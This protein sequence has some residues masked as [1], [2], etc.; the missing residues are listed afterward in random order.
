M[1]GSGAEQQK[2]SLSLDTDQRAG[3]QVLQVRELTKAFGPKALW[4]GSEIR[5][6]ARRADRDHRA[7]RVG[8]DDAAE[9]ADRARP[10]PTRATFKWGANLNIGY[11][12]QRLDDFDPENTVIEEIA[13]STA[14]RE[15]PGSPRTCWR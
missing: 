5:R 14:R 2:I 4:T 6:Q 7:Q 1:I 9:D 12:D 13:A 15:G 11:Y 3:D 10:T 8:Q